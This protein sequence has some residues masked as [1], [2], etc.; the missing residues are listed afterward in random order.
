M[1]DKV[2]VSIT[3]ELTSRFHREIEMTRA[4]AEALEKRLKSAKGWE[5]EE[6]A[7]DYGYGYEGH[8]SG[9]IDDFIIKEVAAKES[10]Q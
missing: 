6:L 3:G 10:K 4:E 5:M 7:A 2:I 1:S 8:S 9:E